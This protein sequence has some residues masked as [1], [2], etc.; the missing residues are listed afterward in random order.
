MTRRRIAALLLVAAAAAGPVAAGDPP[1]LP[2]AKA[3]SGAVPPTAPPADEA[4]PRLD[5]RA[6][7]LVDA[8]T[9]DVL[10]AHEGDERLPIAS[11]TKLMT[12]YVALKELPLRKR[13]TAAPYTPTTA[14]S[15]LGLQPG[16]RISVRD[17][18]YGLILQSGNDAA[19]DLALAAAGSEDRFVRLMNRYAAALGLSDTHYANPI[20]LDE[21]G[22]YSTAS[23]LTALA[24][25]LMAIPGFAKISASRGA[26][27]RSLRP[28][29]RIDTRVDLLYELPWATG[30]KTGYTLGAG[31]VL[32]GAG[33]LDGVQLISAVLGTESEAAR[34]EETEEL[35]TYGFSLHRHEVPVSKREELARPAVRWTDEE[36]PLRAARSV[37][38][39][40]RREQQ[41]TV[42]VE[43]PSEVE[44]PIR[45]GAALGQATVSLDGL[46]VARVPLLA[47]RAVPEASALDKVR[48]VIG[49]NLGWLLLAVFAI[50]VAIVLLGR[51]RR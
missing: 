13:V 37:A 32:V 38:I 19:F 42:E 47:A 3:S 23:D 9:G 14:E 17:L 45:R 10:A 5:A 35:L 33:R 6:W 2:V 36:L 20:G 34:D 40:V 1:P 4:G 7:A 18:L 41:L 27:L 50:L 30:I 15:L 25:R 16:E 26:V 28:P 31:Y 46:P 48:D 11:A 43:A 24:R 21:P 39:G 51:R 29:R 8:R 44:G 22:N 49:D 12:A